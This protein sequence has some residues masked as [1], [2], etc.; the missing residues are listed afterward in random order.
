[1]IRKTIDTGLPSLDQPFSWATQAGGL[2][3]T[4][5]GPVTMDGN[6]R[7]GAIDEQARLT[8][9]NLQRAVAAADAELP[10]VAQVL[11][12]MKDATHMPAID[13]VYR[14]FFHPP[15]PNRLSV[16]VKDFVHPEMLIEI[17]AYVGLGHRDRSPDGERSS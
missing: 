15:Y 4:A 14:E 3:F 7:G 17:V 8:F 1:M 5:H 9:S 10:D 6:I 13:R 16:V 2:L 11:I 12:Y